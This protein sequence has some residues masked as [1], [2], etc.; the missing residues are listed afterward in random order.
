MLLYQC[1][2]KRLNSDTTLPKLTIHNVLLFFILFFMT[3]LAYASSCRELIL[4]SAKQEITSTLWNW[5]SLQ[6]SEDPVTGPCCEPHEPSAR[7][8]TAFLTSVLILL[9]SYTSLGLSFWFLV[10]VYAFLSISYVLHESPIWSSLY[11]IALIVVVFAS[12][13]RH[14]GSTVAVNC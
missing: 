13:P 6:C 12:T 7:P 4:N 11:F 9:Y 2:L 5:D 14:E 1:N 8:H 3:S 10:I